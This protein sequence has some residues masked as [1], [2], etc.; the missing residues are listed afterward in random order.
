M[1]CGEGGNKLVVWDWLVVWDDGDIYI[2]IYI[3]NSKTKER[4]GREECRW[5]SSDRIYTSFAGV[6]I[7][8]EDEV[9]SGWYARLARWLGHDD[10]SPVRA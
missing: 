8:P 9:N 4:G 5:R 7:E 6:S 2:S 3:L 10:A 1:L